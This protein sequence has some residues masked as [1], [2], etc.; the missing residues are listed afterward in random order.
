MASKSKRILPRTMMA[1]MLVLTLLSGQVFSVSAAAGDTTRVSVDSSGVQAN[2]MSRFASV[3]A[4]GRFVVFESDANNLVAGDTNG[5]ND[6]FVKDRQTGQTSRVSV[7]SAGLESNG[8]SGDSAISADGRFVAFSS[9]ATNLVSGDTNGVAD[10]FLRDRQL[11]TTTRISVGSSA[12]QANN[13]SD[14]NT[15][16]SSDGRFV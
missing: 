2:G 9:A 15:S 6:I 3:S 13:S 5:T 11:G 8:D 1:L 14:S 4:D 10:V 16:I 7:D 12:E